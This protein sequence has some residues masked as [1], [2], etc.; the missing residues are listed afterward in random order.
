MQDVISICFIA[1]PAILYLPAGHSKP[2]PAKVLFKKALPPTRSCL[3]QTVPSGGGKAFLHTIFYSLPSHVHI[4]VLQREL[5]SKKRV[6]VEASTVRR[7]LREAGYQ[8]MPR[9]KNKKYT[10]AE[11]IVRKAFASP[12]PL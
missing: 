3:S 4:H 9:A 1:Q 10:A 12:F 8:W 5:A 6:I 2:R 7:H 11:R